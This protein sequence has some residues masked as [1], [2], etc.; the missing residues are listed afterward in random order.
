MSETIVG[1]GVKHPVFSPPSDAAL[2]IPVT[3]SITIVCAKCSSFAV[4][5]RSEAPV[6]VDAGMLCDIASAK[7]KIYVL[8]MNTEK[9]VIF[10]ANWGLFFVWRRCS[11]G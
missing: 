7:S 3:W 10:R 1:V 11:E 2:I 5:A 8:F 6:D 9:M 4:R